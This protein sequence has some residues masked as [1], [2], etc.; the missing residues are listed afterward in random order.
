M[1]LDG[2]IEPVEAP[3]A[4]LEEFRAGFAARAVLAVKRQERLN[5]ANRRLE[6]ASR[7]MEGIGQ[8]T[9]EID[10]EVYWLCRLKYGPQ[11]WSDPEFLRDSE[12]RGLVQRVV[13]RSDRVI[14]QGN[15]R[16]GNNGRNPPSLLRSYGGTSGC[17]VSH[18]SHASHNSHVG[19]VVLS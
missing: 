10:A 13:G 7:L 14:S 18:V 2:L 5:A 6:S 19:K 9:H 1:M 11:C 17:K 4:V 16:N 3:R 15:G 12:K 8:K